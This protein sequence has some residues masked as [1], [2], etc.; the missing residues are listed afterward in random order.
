[1]EKEP[2]NHKLLKEVHRRVLKLTHDM[3]K[4]NI[5][6]FV[7]IMNKPLRLFF[8]NIWAGIGRGVGI[9]IGFTVFASFMLIGLRWLGALNLP[10]I[11]GFVAEIV[12]VVQHQLEGGRTP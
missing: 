9:A 3:E 1:M 2:E 5:A 4:A 12:K 11:G 7:Q 8:M 10:I 6:D